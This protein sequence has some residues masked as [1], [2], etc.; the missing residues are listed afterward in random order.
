MKKHKHLKRPHTLRLASSP[1]GLTLGFSTLV[2]LPLSGLAQQTS[3]STPASREASQLGVVKVEDTA[4]DPNPNAEVG[5]PYKA[6]TSGDERHTRPL[7]ETPQLISVLTKAHIDDS[8]YTDLRAI[9]DAQP[10]ITI[11]TG[12]NGNA[13][14]DR[15]VIRGQEARSDV[16]VDGLRDP[17]MTVRESFAIEQLEISK[18]PNSGFAGRGTS[19]GAVNAITKQATTAYSFAKLSPAIGSDRYTR[20]TLDFNHSFGA[21]FALRANLLYGYEE[22]PARA[23]ADR[24]R[25]GA[26][27]SGLIAA[28]DRLSVTLDFYG[29]R[30]SENPDLGSFLRALPPDR[31]PAQ[32]VPAYAQDQDF[33]DSDVN[34]GT[35]R[36]RYDFSDTMH[37]TNLTRY[38]TS[39]N[40]YVVT[41]AADRTTNGSNPGGVYA[42][43]GLSTHQ[44]WQE[45]EYTANQTNL[46]WTTQL[47]GLE[48]EFIFGAEYTDHAVLNGLYSV[49]NLGAFNCITGTAAVLNTYCATTASGAPVNGLNTLL[50]R[51]IVKGNYDIDWQV[52]TTA[53]S[54]LDTLDLTDKLTVFAGIRSDHFDYDLVLQSTNTLAKSSYAYS[55]TLVNGQVGVTYEVAPGGV[56]YASFATASDINGGE[57]DVGTS[58]GYGGVV[59]FNGSVAGAKPETSINLELGTKWNLF[60]DTLL[61]TGAV[62]QV[63]KSDVMEGADYAAFGTFN[64][65]KSRVRGAEFGATGQILPKLTA[66]A[67]IAV[68][69]SEILESSTA[70]AVGKAISNFAD[71]SGSAQLKWAFT[72]DF[73]IGGAAK[74]ESKRYGGQ[75]DTAAAYQADG[76]YSQPV[77]AYSVYDLFAT[78]R[79]NRNLDARLNIGNVTNKEFYLAAYRAGFFLYKGDARTARLTF[80]YD[81]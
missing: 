28:S 47:L 78:Y 24:E 21:R 68:M 69:D 26:A 40:G 10:G 17:G 58:S 72:P 34:T 80:T 67:G 75:P 41:G 55:D 43:A 30:A 3:G 56:V 65:G 14:G 52:K 59:I 32:G 44:G 22:V 46:F 19:G 16:F 4:I 57:S 27:L 29:L 6:K 74:Y 48:N 77:P 31:R 71:V 35:A 20:A 42:T 79:F 15:Y 49:A 36:V 8:G 73:T 60:G 23:P 33:L 70:S 61:L 62:F 25:K 39:D 51:Q 64:T 50:N 18:G 12:E 2:L 66:Q 76:Q 1:A 63:T 11:G 7:A 38:G 81:F 45:V 9:L 13:F 5:V 37:L 54:L 53:F